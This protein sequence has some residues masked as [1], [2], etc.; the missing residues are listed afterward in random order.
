MAL[1]PPEVPLLRSMELLEGFNSEKIAFKLLRKQIQDDKNQ[2]YQNKNHPYRENVLTALKLCQVLGGEYVR[3]FCAQVTTPVYSPSLLYEVC[4]SIANHI[5][6]INRRASNL[7]SCHIM[8]LVWLKPVLKKCWSN[9]G[10]VI[11]TKVF[12]IVGGHDGFRSNHRSQNNYNLDK[13]QE[14]IELMN[15]IEEAIPHFYSV[16][17]D[18]SNKI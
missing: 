9:S 18:G 10:S 16:M 2:K 17:P 7:N 3:E 8:T 6:Q 4:K 12:K 13:E 5:F 1:I 11:Q 15:F 14:F